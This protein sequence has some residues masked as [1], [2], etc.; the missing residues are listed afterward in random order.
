MSSIFAEVSAQCT[1]PLQVASWLPLRHG[2][3]HRDTFIYICSKGS[4]DKFYRPLVE[5]ASQQGNSKCRAAA[6]DAIQK[7]LGKF[8][9][10]LKVAI[11]RKFLAL[12]LLDTC[13]DL[14]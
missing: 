2:F 9:T 12:Q 1:H 6:L 3:W 13:K 4:A 10:R 7:L 11:S 14:N 5:A 8:R